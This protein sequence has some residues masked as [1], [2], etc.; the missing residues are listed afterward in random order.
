MAIVKMNKFTLL[1]FE[2]QKAK[3]LEAMQSF[4]GVQF[5][6]LQEDGI[7]EEIEILKGLNKDSVG[8]SCVEFEDNLLKIKFTLDLLQEY[9][10]KKS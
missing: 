7:E 5:I 8:T 10:P 2:S 1:S 4:Q 9:A 3:L 6:N